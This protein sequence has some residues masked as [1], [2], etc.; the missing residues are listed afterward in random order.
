MTDERADASPARSVGLVATYRGAGLPRTVKALGLTSFLQDVASEM[1][2]PLLP[3]FLAS[4]G[5]GPVALG[6]MESAAEGALALLKGAAGRWSDRVGRRKPFAAAGYGL[7]AATRPLMA[8]AT[9]VWQVVGLRVL[10]RIAK[11][12]RTAPR[13]AMIADATPPTDRGFAFAFHRGLDHLGAAVGP[14]LAALIL[15]AEPGR[16]RLVFALAT[17][18]AVAGWLSLQLGTREPRRA[19]PRADG[20]PLTAAPSDDGATTSPNESPLPRQ[21]GRATVRGVPPALRRPLLAF[22]LFSLGNASDAF[23]LLRA[24]QLGY[25]PT[26]L[27]FLW[28]AFH[29]AKWLASAPAGRVA[30]RLGPRRPILLGWA[31]YALVYI[32][33]GHASTGF[34]VL[35]LLVLYA[36]HYGLT[37]GAERAM[38]VQLAGAGGRAMGAGTALGAYHLTTGLGVFAASLLFGILWERLSPSVAFDLGAVLAA[39]A[40][41]VLAFGE[42]IGRR[43]ADDRSS[44]FD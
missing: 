24:A 41:V 39:T 31:I 8:L 13:D 16:V 22:F 4:L 5:G 28:S 7:S 37:E 6:A 14:L 35:P 21:G 18:P 12:L 42:A 15:A 33:F 17:I 10:D 29:V 20:S 38:V 3:A 43:P 25:S 11:G 30:D 34:A 36:V 23:L 26:G 1:V 40:T 44:R 9:A 19:A 27:A 2:Y 32:G